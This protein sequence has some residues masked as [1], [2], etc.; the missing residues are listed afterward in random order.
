MERASTLSPWGRLARGAYN[1]LGVKTC[2]AGHSTALVLRALG[3]HTSETSSRVASFDSSSACA[4]HLASLSRRPVSHPR[5]VG[6]QFVTVLEQH[7]AAEQHNHILMSRRRERGSTASG[8]GGPGREHGSRVYR[9]RGG[10]GQERVDLPL[11][12]GDELRHGPEGAFVSAKFHENEC[13]GF[14]RVIWHN[15]LN[16]IC[17]VLLMLRYIGTPVLC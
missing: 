16:Y 7:N 10:T 5:R 2:A 11:G 3:G 1:A 6:R 9:C 17:K 13:S 12:G 15:L 14:C 8:R 4:T